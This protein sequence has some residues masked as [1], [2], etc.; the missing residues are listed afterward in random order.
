[1]PGR[2]YALKAA[3]IPACAALYRAGMSRRSIAAHYG[4]SDMAIRNA[5]KLAGQPM[6]D[7]ALAAALALSKDPMKHV[8][9]LTPCRPHHEAP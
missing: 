7:R 9:V 8:Q 6:R 4:V 3:Q 5:L 2:N 1:M